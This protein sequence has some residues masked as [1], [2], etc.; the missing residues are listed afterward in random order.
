MRAVARLLFLSG[1]RIVLPGGELQAQF[2]GKRLVV[3][4]FLLRVFQDDAGLTDLVQYLLDLL[5]GALIRMKLPGLQVP[6]LF[7]AGGMDDAAVRLQRFQAEQE[8]VMRRP[9]AGRQAEYLIV[10]V[11]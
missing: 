2:P 3:G 9:V 8:I 11:V 5:G 6:D 1:R 10:E 7:Q 4:K